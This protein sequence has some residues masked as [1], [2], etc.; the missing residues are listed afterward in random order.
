MYVSLANEIFSRWN[1]RAA[2]SLDHVALNP[3]R[4]GA[5]K[6]LRRWR[7]VGRADLQNL[8]DE[9]RIVWDPVAHHDRDRRAGSRAP[10]PWPHRMALGANIA[11]KMLTTRSKLRSASSLRLV[12]SPSW[13]RQFVRPSACARLF[14]ASTRLLAMSTPRTSAPSRAAG[15]AVVPSPHPRSSTFNPAVMPRPATTAF[16]ALRACSPRCA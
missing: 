4:H 5:D 15:R 13:N 10:S 7:R 11:P 9:C 14:P 3:P 16:A 1:P 8:R 2:K 12:A 6:A